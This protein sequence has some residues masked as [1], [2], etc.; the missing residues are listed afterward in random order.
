M[1]ASNMSAWSSRCQR[2]LKGS[3]TLGHT[4]SAGHLLA[5]RQSTQSSSLGPSSTVPCIHGVRTAV[6]CI[7][8]CILWMVGLL[9][10]F[11]LQEPK[12]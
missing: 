4:L 2:S 12:K 10:Q 9:G 6:P 3:P 11:A 1:Q 8:V 5:S 7:H